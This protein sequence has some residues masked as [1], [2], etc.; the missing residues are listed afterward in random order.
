MVCKENATELETRAG[1]RSADMH[2]L[3]ECNTEANSA[4]RTRRV[5]IGL[6]ANQTHTQISPQQNP[7]YW[8]MRANQSNKG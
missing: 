5:S 6:N 8:S 2:R 1:Q 3:K 4:K 7:T